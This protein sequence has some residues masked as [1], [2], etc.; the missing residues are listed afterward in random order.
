[1]LYAFGFGRVGVVVSDLVLLDPTP[2]PHGER[3][4][5]GVRLEL[6]VLTAGALPGSE[7]SARPIAVE[8]PIWRADLLESIGNPGSLDR[9]HHHP[10][11]ERWEPGDRDFVDE[12]NA[13]P[14]GFV[15]KRLSDLDGILDDGGVPRG[16]VDPSD[17]DELRQVV[18]EILD[19][20]QRLLDQVRAR[21][22]A[23]AQAPVDDYARIGWL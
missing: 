1:M 2:D 14:L 18:P 4:E 16:D 10:R 21:G 12:M 23:T 6:R 22:P 8:R 9:A 5:Q 13:D 7:S 11:F 20:V 3:S 15:A 17:A 19:A